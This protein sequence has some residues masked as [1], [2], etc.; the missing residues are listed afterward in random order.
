[1]V[2]ILC[3]PDDGPALW[4]AQ[5][6][7]ASRVPDVTVVSVEELV[8]SRCIVSRM[9]DNGDSGM[10]RLADGRVLRPESITGLVNRVRH[11][12]TQHFAHANA[13]DRA[14]AT[15]ELGAFL[16]A[17][18]NGIAGRVL[19]PARPF[20]LGGGVMYPYSPPAPAVPASNGN[21]HVDQTATKHD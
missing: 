1:M 3:H 12:P 15:A 8:F 4:L 19:N 2:V 11:L 16:L 17:W 14:Y 7:T 6:L 20:A 10:V 21:Q 18:L 13:D 5:T 9:T